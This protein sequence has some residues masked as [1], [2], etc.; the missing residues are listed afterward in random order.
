MRPADLLNR[1]SDEPFR[2]FRVHLSDGS[3]LDVPDRN[4]VIVGRS[5]A[6]LPNRFGKDDGGHRIA[7]NWQTIALIHIV[8]FSDFGRSANGRSRRHPGR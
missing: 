2:P 6:V 8:E 4:M 5:T 7:L 1:L 3:R